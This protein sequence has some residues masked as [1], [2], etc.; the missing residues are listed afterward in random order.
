MGDCWNAC[1]CANSGTC[2]VTCTAGS[3]ALKGKAC[4][5]M[6]EQRDYMV[7]LCNGA[8]DGNG[9][10]R[11]PPSGDGGEAS[12]KGFGEGC[13]V[14]AG[15]DLILK[16]Y[17]LADRPSASLLIFRNCSTTNENRRIN[18]ILAIFVIRIPSE[19]HAIYIDVFHTSFHMTN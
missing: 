8:G 4:S 6:C 15:G 11:P 16:A 5:D 18:V 1:S 13:P 10:G 2:G 17:V 7:Q 12:R 9:G 14:F 3:K 19:L